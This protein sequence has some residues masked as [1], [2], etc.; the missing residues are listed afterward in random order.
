MCT[1]CCNLGLV[2]SQARPNQPQP[3]R[4]QYHA[5]GRKGLVTL[6]RFPCAT[7]R[8]P[9]RQ[10]DWLQLHNSELIVKLLN[11]KS[12][13]AKFVTCTHAS[14]HSTYL[15]NGFIFVT[16]ALMHSTCTR[17]PTESHQ[18]LPSPC[19][20]LKAICAGVGWV[21]LARLLGLVSPG[22]IATFLV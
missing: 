20:I 21:W 10:S 22:C 18:T 12:V 8:L 7:S 15:L 19:M 5:R 11:R 4:F 2:V 16:S 3:D 17:K 13:V 14:A 9:R 1:C 6:G